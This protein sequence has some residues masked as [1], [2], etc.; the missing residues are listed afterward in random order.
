MLK[1]T[2]GKERYIKARQLIIQNLAKGPIA[3]SVLCKQM[4]F[5]SVALHKAV[6][7]GKQSGQLGKAFLDLLHEEVIGIREVTKNHKQIF[8]KE[9]PV[10]LPAMGPAVYFTDTSKLDLKIAE[11][12]KVLT[13]L[14]AEKARAEVAGELKALHEQ[15]EAKLV[16]DFFNFK[17][18]QN[19]DSKL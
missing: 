5:S 17:Q 10:E 18:T 14:L 19:H 8:L 11:A 12:L 16:E 7:I 9:H 15:K 2:G 13:R 4:G 3:P 1:G 6:R